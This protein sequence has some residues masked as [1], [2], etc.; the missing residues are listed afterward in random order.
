MTDPGYRAEAQDHLLIDEPNRNEEN[1]ASA[2][3]AS[4][5]MNGKKV[6]TRRGYRYRG[7]AVLRVEC[8]SRTELHGDNFTET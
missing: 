6:L 4:T 5:S 7:L 8:R 2:S 3:I 1:E